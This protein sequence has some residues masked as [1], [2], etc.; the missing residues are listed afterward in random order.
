V[1]VYPQHG[2]EWE[3]YTKLRSDGAFDEVAHTDWNEGEI[4]DNSLSY[5]ITH[6]SSPTATVHHAHE[7]LGGRR[8]TT[9][10]ILSL[11]T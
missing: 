10:T 6:F 1:K 7:F 9:F 5:L 8:T 4:F 11:Y 2:K 3:V